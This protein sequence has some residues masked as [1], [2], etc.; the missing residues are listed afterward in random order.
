MKVAAYLHPGIRRAHHSPV[1]YLAGSC[2]R[3]ERRDEP[4]GWV[5]R[6]HLT[7]PIAIVQRAGDHLGGRNRRARAGPSRTRV[8]R[9]AISP[10]SQM[11]IWCREA[12]IDCDADRAHADAKDRAMAGRVG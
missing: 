7:L 1:R 10:S 5:R 11:P 6:Y 12:A 8:F 3:G 9:M 4:L 2:H